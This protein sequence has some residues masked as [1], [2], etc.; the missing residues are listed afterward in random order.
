MK[1]SSGD[2]ESAWCRSQ[3]PW[4]LEVMTVSQCSNVIFGKAKSCRNDLS[5]SFKRG[6]E[7]TFNIIGIYRPH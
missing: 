6:R 3:T 7:I 5:E 2:E 1:K 4:T